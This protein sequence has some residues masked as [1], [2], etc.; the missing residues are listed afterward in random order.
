MI[1]RVGKVY[2]SKEVVYNEVFGDVLSHI[3]FIP[4]RVE[5]LA[6]RNCFEYIGSSV[7]FDEIPQGT[8]LPVYKIEVKTDEDGVLESVDVIKVIDFNWIN[9]VDWYMAGIL[10]A[11]SIF[12]IFT[13]IGISCVAAKIFA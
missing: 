4:L 7:E 9:K 10:F 6:Y 2:I 13:W 12:G 1:N 8:E 5:Y 3:K 11:S